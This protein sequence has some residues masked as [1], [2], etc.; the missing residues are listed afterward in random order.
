MN[1]TKQIKRLT[2]MTELEYRLEIENYILLMLSANCKLTD[3]QKVIVNKTFDNAYMWNDFTFNNM[4]K[5]LAK[6][7]SNK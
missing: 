2:K 4:I 7:F 5:K 1:S 3:E 6:E